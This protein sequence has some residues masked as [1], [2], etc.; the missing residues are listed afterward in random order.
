M[1]EVSRRKLFAGFAAAPFLGA[2]AARGEN[3]A[4]VP[5]HK[6]A[7][8]VSGR[9]MMRRRYFPN[10][11]LVSQNGRKMKFYDDMLK[12]KIVLIN[13]MYAD[14]EGVC[15]TITANLKHVQKL[16]RDQINHEILF[17]SITVKPETDSPAKL[18][19]YA[20]MHG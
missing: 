17:Y 9:E 4:P 7:P 3:P 6:F 15:P 14:C 10:F 5:A 2:L 19:E 8:R 13:F 16:L 1:S 12:E 20:K 18:M 11:E